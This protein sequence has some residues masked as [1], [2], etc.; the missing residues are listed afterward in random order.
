MQFLM[1]KGFVDPPENFDDQ[2]RANNGEKEGKLEDFRDAGMGEGQGQENV[3]DQIEDF[4]QLEE[5]KGDSSRPS[6]QPTE[7]DRSRQDDDQQPIDV[8]DDFDAQMEEIDQAE[9]N[10]I[11]PIIIA[12]R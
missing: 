10:S 3:S 2:N 4:G 7:S 12:V 5:L 1:F 8:D 11:R 9:G 6:E